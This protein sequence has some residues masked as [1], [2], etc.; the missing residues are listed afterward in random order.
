MRPTWISANLEVKSYDIFL[1]MVWKTQNTQKTVF[2]GIFLI[3]LEPESWR[4]LQ[5]ADFYVGRKKKK[6]CCFFFFFHHA[7]TWKPDCFQ[8]VQ[9]GSRLAKCCCLLLGAFEVEKKPK[10]EP[11]DLSALRRLICHELLSYIVVIN[12]PCLLMREEWSS[13]HFQEDTHQGNI[14]QQMY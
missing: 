10:Y 9:I 1:E 12:A 2:L 11:I 5:K 13:A 7:F 6:D 3:Y 14:A 4:H 8:N